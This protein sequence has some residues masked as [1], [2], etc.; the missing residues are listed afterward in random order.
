MKTSSDSSLIFLSCVSHSD[1]VKSSLE[2]FCGDAHSVETGLHPL[3]SVVSFTSTLSSLI[4][5][6]SILVSN[7]SFEAPVSPKVISS[8][9]GDLEGALLVGD[10]LL[11]DD[12]DLDLDVSL[13]E[14]N[15]DRLS[16]CFLVFLNF[17]DSDFE[18][19]EDD[20][21]LDFLHRCGD[22]DSDFVL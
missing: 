16:F 20:R 22:T 17:G 13:C 8:F 4:S 18:L 12:F 5:T 7:E 10:K 14:T 19:C 3:T 21:D 1:D 15:L 9:L 11:S 6:T 2:V